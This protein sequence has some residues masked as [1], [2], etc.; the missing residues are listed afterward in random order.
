MN[1][2]V[3]LASVV[4]AEDEQID[5]ADRACPRFAVPARGPGAVDIG[6]L[7]AGEIFECPAKA[8]RYAKRA[9]QQLPQATVVGARRVGADEPCSADPAGSDQPCRLGPFHLTVDRCRRNPETTRQL[10]H[11]LLSFR[12]V[13]DVGE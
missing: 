11:G 2:G 7:H 5:V 10:G 4:V 3:E 8:G 13:Q 9:D 12:A 6:R 1:R